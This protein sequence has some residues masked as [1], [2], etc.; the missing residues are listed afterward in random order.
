MVGAARGGVSLGFWVVVGV[1]FVLGFLCMCSAEMTSC[2]NHARVSV[3]LVKIWL[4]TDFGWRCLSMMVY[5]HGVGSKL[6]F[7]G[8]FLWF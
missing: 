4:C 5:G 6:V 3:G 1:G 8:W 2:V 7:L